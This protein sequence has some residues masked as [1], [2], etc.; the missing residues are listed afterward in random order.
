MNSFVT[1]NL[2]FVLKGKKVLIGVTGSIAAFKVCDI[3]RYLRD[4]GAFVRVGLSQGAENFVTQ[5][6]LEALSGNPVL[7]G[8]WNNGA[9]TEAKSENTGVENNFRPTFHIDYARWADVMVIAPC[10]A[11][12]IAKMANGFADDLLSTELLAFRGPVLIAPAMN[13][14][15]YAHPAVQ[16]NILK[17]KSRGVI[18][19]GP[20]EGDTSCGETGL[21]RML[22]PEQI[23]EQVAETFYGAENGKKAL[24]SLGPTLSAIDPV[25]YITN[26]SSGLMGAS[27]CWAFA[28]A[29]YRVTAVCG[30]SSIALPRGVE[31]VRVQTNSEMAKAIADAFPKSDIF[32]SAAAVLDWTIKNPARE[33]I[34]KR[35]GTLPLELEE[36][37][38][39][40]R[41]MASHKM[42]HQFT[43]GFAAETNNPIENGFTKL[44]LKKCD[45]IFVN[46]VSRSDE[47]FESP[48][49]SGWWLKTSQDPVRFERSTKPELARKILNQLMKQQICNT[50]SAVPSN[51]ET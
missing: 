15:M 36:G 4:C 40:L 39:I 31:T 17:L 28:Q 30:P 43:L 21:G 18:F 13:P 51:R 12:F 38:D 25:R 46:D 1:E 35:E 45:A 14:A 3:V 26:R 37:I 9:S 5:T 29:G 48:M 27:L 50:A 47:G 10:T 44:R 11:H 23:V 34:K 19:V 24:I 22:E 41:W 32:I 8:F 6:T 20:T 49:N 16:E 33:K 7:S 2:S 42:P